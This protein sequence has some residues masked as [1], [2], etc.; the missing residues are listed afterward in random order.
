MSV[1]DLRPGAVPLDELELELRRLGGVRFVGFDEEEGALVVQLLAPGA[2]DVADLRERAARLSRAHVA[3]P[4]I[5]EVDNGEAMLELG[6]QR[7]ELLAVLPSLDSTEVEVHLAYAGL[8]TVGR[9]RVGMGPMESATATLDALRALRLPV[10]YGVLAA[11][12]LAGG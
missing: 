11:S 9:G 3:G 7:V 6:E 8:R 10:Q 4:V 1:D 2:S 12:T 5:V